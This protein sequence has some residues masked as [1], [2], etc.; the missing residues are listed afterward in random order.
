MGFGRYSDEA[1]FNCLGVLVKSQVVP[2]DGNE[3][4]RALRFV[5]QQKDM[6]SSGSGGNLVPL[7]VAAFIID[8]LRAEA[9]T[10]QMGAR[11]VPMTSATLKVVRQTGD[12]TAA[13][14]AEGAT[15]TAS[16]AALD[17]VTLTARRIEALTKV[18]MELFEDSDDPVSIGQV[19]ATSIA[20]AVALEL[21]RVALRGTGTAPEPRGIRNQ[22]GIQPYSL[23]TPNGGPA[24]W[25]TLIAMQSLLAQSNVVGSG[26]VVHPRTGYSL[27]DTKDSTGQFVA[28]PAAISGL[29][30]AMTAALPVNLTEG[31]SSTCTEIYAGDWSELLLGMRVNLSITTLSELFRAEGKV[32]LVGRVRADVGVAHGASFVYAGDVTN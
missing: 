1:V 2:V 12:V 4:A 6:L 27:A 25:S 15:I 32:G 29:R 21:D 3:V 23:G 19:V 17:S 26:F 14:L 30:T 16:D 9:V 31:T 28:P 24:S 20:K 18:G 7:P 8:M 5:G 22:P 10:A 13:W 11:S